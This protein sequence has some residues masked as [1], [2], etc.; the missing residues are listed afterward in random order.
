MI[1]KILQIMPIIAAAGSIA[2]AIVKTIK[3]GKKDKI[4]K[5]A[6]VVK[7]IPGLVIEAEEVLGSGTGRAK[8]TYVLNQLNI[9]CLQSGIDF[10]EAGLKAEVENVLSTPQ[11]KEAI[12]QEEK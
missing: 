7:A 11:K 9:K 12:C 2:V 5:L 8:L 3:A 6:K 4:I 1:A 10:D